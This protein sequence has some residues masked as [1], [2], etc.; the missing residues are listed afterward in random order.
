M[1]SPLPVHVNR[2]ELHDLAVPE[3]YETVGSFEIRL[4][5]HGEPSHVH[6]HLDDSLSS[7]AAIEA[8]NHYVDGESQRRV[9][10]NVREGA[11][12]R[13]KL[14]V[15]VGYGATTRYVDVD[16]SK[17]IETTQSVEVDESLSQPQPKEPEESG[18]PLEKSPALPV[19]SLAAL[20]LLLAVS[21]AL[22]FRQFVVALGASV[23]FLGVAIALYALV[24][25]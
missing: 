3:S 16:I 12:I 5:N 6:L 14:K 24:G 1:P 23:V 2:E 21:A 4:I 7:V 22:L 15:A 25:D 11:S 19:L 18:G 9:S 17:P 8:T 20:A 10:V 13:G